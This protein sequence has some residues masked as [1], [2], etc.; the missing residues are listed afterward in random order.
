MEIYKVKNRNE[1]LLKELLNV[2]ESSVKATH[3]FL[4]DKEIN[5][6]KE[7][8]PRALENA[9]N[10]VVAENRSVPIAFM[11]TENG[12][13]EMLFVS[14]MQ[15][16]KGIGK[17]LVQYG[18]KNYGIFEATVNEQNPRAVGFYKHMGFKTYKRTDLDEEGRPYPLLYM[19]LM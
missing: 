19:K 12:R 9:E 6:I 2:W 7:Y 14:P 4:S 13:I 18:I 15:I 10:L 3:L 5:E 11:G 8:V 1:E 17:E 16:G